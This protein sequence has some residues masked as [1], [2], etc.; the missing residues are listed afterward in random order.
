ALRY[1]LPPSHDSLTIP[2]IEATGVLEVL[3]EEPSARVSGA[4]IVASGPVTVEGKSLQRYLAQDVPSSAV[5]AI[6]LPA[7]RAAA[8]SR[9]WLLALLGAL[10]AG[11]I[12][13]ALLWHSRAT[14]R[15]ERDPAGA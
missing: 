9:P 6:A 15:A 13:A 3:L 10:V 12:G 2:V 4:G 11:A 7:P 8:S 14:T 1:E 5:L